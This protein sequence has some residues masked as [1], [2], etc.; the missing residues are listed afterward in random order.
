MRKAPRRLSRS[1][2]E[3]FFH[4]VPSRVYLGQRSRSRG[5]TPISD[6]RLS[7]AAGPAGENSAGTRHSIL[8]PVSASNQTGTMRTTRPAGA[9]PESDQVRGQR[10]GGGALGRTTRVPWSR[11]TFT[12]SLMPSR[13]G[14][15]RQGQ[16]Y[17]C[18]N[19]S[20]GAPHR[21]QASP[22]PVSA[23]CTLGGAPLGTIPNQLP[24]RSAGGLGLHSYSRKLQVFAWTMG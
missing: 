2:S 7:G 10:A 6:A 23:F 12:A 15:W 8:V 17:T 3:R 24:G 1:D 20:Q 9:R 18:R 14:T 22:R 4:P 13:L 21:L 11:S 5:R 16:A 19:V